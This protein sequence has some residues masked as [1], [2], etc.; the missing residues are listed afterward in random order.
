MAITPIKH[1]TRYGAYGM[2]LKNDQCLLTLKK[3]G[4]YKGLWGL[5]GGAIEFEET[6]EEALK[7]EF[8][9]ET[10]LL[11]DQIELVSVATFNGAYDHHGERYKF[12]HVGII[13][14][15]LD[16]VPAPNVTPEEEMRWILLKSI[17]KEE[18]TPF[19]KHVIKNVH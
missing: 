5:P 3:T 13:Y 8:L 18:V 6:P 11:V 17:K 9:E 16:F 19:V 15:V 7:R 1:L 2:L 12:H 10:A 14:R 4:P